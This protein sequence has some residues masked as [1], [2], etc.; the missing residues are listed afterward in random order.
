MGVKAIMCENRT[1]DYPVCE[2]ETKTWREASMKAI[3]KILAETTGAKQEWVNTV[4]KRI[5]DS[6]VTKKLC[7]ACAVRFFVASLVLENKETLDPIILEWG[8]T[9]ASKIAVIQHA[10]AVI[11]DSYKKMKKTSN[12][13]L[14][15]F[16]IWFTLR[17][18]R[19]E[20][21][22]PKNLT[23]D[24]RNLMRKMRSKGESLRDL[25]Y[26]LDRSVSTVQQNCQGVEAI[27][28]GFH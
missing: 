11:A 9:I 22:Q 7:S 28:N 5:I 20:Y 3:Q 4:Y 23:K 25:A 18:K 16:P 14:G 19:M 12:G 13:N 21:K 10:Q 2:T 26:I 24:E 17:V 1:C 6:E 15:S 27:E 8:L